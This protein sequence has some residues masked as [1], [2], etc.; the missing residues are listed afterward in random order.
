M[1][2]VFKKFYTGKQFGGFGRID[3]NLYLGPAYLHYVCSKQWDGGKYQFGIMNRGQASTVLTRTAL[4]HMYDKIDRIEF[5][6]NKWRP[7][8]DEKLKEFVKVTSMEN[9]R[10]LNL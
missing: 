4:M 1:G 9:Q 6:P 5:D 7:E 8:W 10:Y 3:E 2:C